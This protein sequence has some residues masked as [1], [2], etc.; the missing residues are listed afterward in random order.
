MLAE[1][2][3]C[4]LYYINNSSLGFFTASIVITSLLG[5]MICYIV[6]TQ[7][8]STQFNTY[9]LTIVQEHDGTQRLIYNNRNSEITHTS[10]F[11]SSYISINTEVEEEPPE[12]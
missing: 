3:S 10:E 8:S 5:C 7:A 2:V 6:W 9:D 4:V 1:T 12:D 11:T